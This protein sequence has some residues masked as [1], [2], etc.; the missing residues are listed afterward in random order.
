MEIIENVTDD[1]IQSKYREICDNLNLSSD[2]ITE[3]FEVYQKVRKDYDLK[4][5]YYKYYIIN[6]TMIY[7]VKQCEIYFI[8]RLIGFCPV[9][10]VDYM[11]LV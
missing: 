6:S 8:D 5:I 11:K 7:L 9:C 2:K 1:I 3:S 4:V 10:C